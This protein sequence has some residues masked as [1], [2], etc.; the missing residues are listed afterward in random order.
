MKAS[1]ALCKMTGIEFTKSPAV[2]VEDFDRMV[3]EI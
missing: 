2:A 1:I 3:A